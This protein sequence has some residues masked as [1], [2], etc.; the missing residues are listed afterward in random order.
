MYSKSPRKYYFSYDKENDDLFLYN[1][2][3]KSKGSVEMGDI[4]LDMNSKKELVGLQIIHATNILKDAV[5]EE[6]SSLVENVLQNLKEC[7][8]EIIMKNDFAI[9]K[10]CF[11]NGD[12]EVKPILTIPTIRESSTA[13]ACSDI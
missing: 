8:V 5:N 3:A 10:M 4:I 12:H 6:E 7:R 13:L 1:P 9:I 11:L 2:K